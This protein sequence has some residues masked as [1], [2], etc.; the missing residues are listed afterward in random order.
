MAT[1]ENVHHPVYDNSH[2]TV[3]IKSFASYVC[4][5]AYWMLS[6]NACCCSCSLVAKI[7]S[8]SAYASL[9]NDLNPVG[10]HYILILYMKGCTGIFLLIIHTWPRDLV[11][12]YLIQINGLLFQKFHCS[13]VYERLFTTH[14]ALYSAHSSIC[15]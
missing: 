12:K 10:K 1:K 13:A 15:S 2:Y 3:K 6:A 14:T 7:T 4:N 8:H 11:V 9:A 5:V